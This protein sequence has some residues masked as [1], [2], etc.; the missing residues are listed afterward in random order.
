MTND[1]IYAMLK[2]THPTA[3]AKWD[4][5][6]CDLLQRVSGRGRVC[7]MMLIWFL[8]DEAVLRLAVI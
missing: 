7:S 8:N 6:V 1:E 4:E 3:S 5:N 2:H